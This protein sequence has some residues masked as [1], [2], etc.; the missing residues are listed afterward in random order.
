MC[1][2]GGSGGSCSTVGMIMCCKWW[3]G[4]VKWYG[5]RFNKAQMDS[6]QEEVN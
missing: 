4:E 6:L 3:Q 5:M 2:G 1:V